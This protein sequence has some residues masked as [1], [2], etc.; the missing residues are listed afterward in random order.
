[1]RIGLD[2]DNTIVCYDAAFHRAALDRGLI[3]TGVMPTKDGVRNFLRAAG[4]EDDWTALQG[5]IYG[6]RMDLAAAFPGV[7]EFMR[8]AREAG[9]AVNIVSHKTRHPYRGEKYD[10]HRAALGWL[11]QQG[12]FDDEALGLDRADVHLELTKDAK[13]ARIGTLDC[14]VFVDDLPELLGEAAFPAGT[15]RVLFDPNDAAPDSPSYAR[16]RSWGE[17]SGLLLGAA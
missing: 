4:R 16:A 14:H 6:A 10:L 7:R 8:K 5:Y 15:Q 9:C 2:F 17:I 3:P 1:M 11:E 13:L 12:F